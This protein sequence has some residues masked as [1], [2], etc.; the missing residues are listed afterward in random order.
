M[1]KTSFTVGRIREMLAQFEDYDEVVCVAA[2][3][4]TGWDASREY[5][6]FDIENVTHSANGPRVKLWLGE[7]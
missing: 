3:R 1:I 7:R 5:E 4:L 6:T 2:V